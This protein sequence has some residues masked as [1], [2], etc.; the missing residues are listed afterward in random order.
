MNCTKYI[1]IRSL[2]FDT[3]F[4]GH[5]I[6]EQYKMFVQKNGTWSQSVSKVNIQTQNHIKYCLTSDRE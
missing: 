5:I 3:S 1:I 4:L 6:L 2:L